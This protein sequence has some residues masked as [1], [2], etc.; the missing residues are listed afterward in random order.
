MIDRKLTLRDR[1]IQETITLLD[2][3]G[4]DVSLRSVAKAAGVSA[5]APYRHFADKAALLGAAAGAG[6]VELQRRLEA[7]DATPDHRQ[8]LVQQGLAYVA[9]AR[10]HPELFRLMF[11]G[12]NRACLPADAN[13]GAFGVMQRRVSS[14]AVADQQVK[15]MACWATVHG[16][17]ILTM[18]ETVAIDQGLMTNILLRLAQDV[19]GV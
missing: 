13:K 2:R 11:A 14:L 3:G 4:D 6:F 16:L 8:G 12:K 15:A 9:F 7:A 18:D 17:A 5:M 1:L 19:E 10:D